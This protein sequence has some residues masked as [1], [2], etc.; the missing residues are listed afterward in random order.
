MDRP[1]KPMCARVDA[2]TTVVHNKVNNI[3]S[4]EKIYVILHCSSGLKLDNEYKSDFNPNL[5]ES[6]IMHLKQINQHFLTIQTLTK[7]ALHKISI[8]FKT[9]YF[10]T[11][12]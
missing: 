11:F 1:N 12:Y 6:L 7:F 5:N 4:V 2:M 3:L 10:R 8:F 9:F